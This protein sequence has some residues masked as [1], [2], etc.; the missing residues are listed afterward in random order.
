MLQISLVKG[1]LII[2]CA[3]HLRVFFYMEIGSERVERLYKEYINSDVLC[4]QV[5]YS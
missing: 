3:Y 4:I 2:V 5:Q 1:P